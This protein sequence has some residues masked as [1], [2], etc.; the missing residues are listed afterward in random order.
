MPRSYQL[1]VTRFS[2]GA[3]NRPISRLRVGL[4][5][6]GLAALIGAF[7]IPLYRLMRFSVESSLYSHI[8]LIPAVSGYFLW[9]NR[10]FLQQTSPGTWPATLG[11]GLAGMMVLTYGLIAVPRGDEDFLFA[12]TLPFLC[13][14]A[15]LVGGFFGDSVLRSLA[16][17]LGFLAFMLPF[18][19]PILHAIETAL[20]HGSA[21]VALVFFKL[22]GMP[23]FNEGLM[24]QLPAFS[25]QVAPECSG[26]HSTLALFITSVVAGQLFLQRGWKRVALALFVLPLALVRNGF[27]VFV[28]GQLCV[29]IGPEMIDSYVHRQGGPIFFALS[30]VPFVFVLWLFVRSERRSATF[31]PFVP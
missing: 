31:T 16:F 13:L 27:R 28:I 19:T 12:M 1:P 11:L 24:F 3:H 9:L 23:V 26:I 7:A 18:P 21:A 17:P 5:A 8:P 30:L 22:S 4:F 14:V 29:R 25:M 2:I 20:Q 10:R 6:F 15:A